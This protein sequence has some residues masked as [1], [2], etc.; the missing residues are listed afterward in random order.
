[1]T[2][3]REVLPVSLTDESNGGNDVPL[4]PR[5]RGTTTLGQGFV[6]I[7]QRTGIVTSEGNSEQIG[8]R[9]ASLS[10]IVEDSGSE[11]GVSQV[12]TQQAPPF[13]P[14]AATPSGEQADALPEAEG[15]EIITWLE[16]NALF[17]FVI[18]VKIAWSYKFGECVW[19]S[20]DK[21][22]HKCTH[23]HT[24]SYTHTHTCVC[25]HILTHTHT[26]S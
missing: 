12:W 1:M 14:T 13:V 26:H 6:G 20:F 2:M 22:T 9:S 11:E 16:Q 25:M 19:V 24:N 18:F 23:A 4:T 10:Q 17:L 21:H 8:S 5:T 7:P 3:I 15:N